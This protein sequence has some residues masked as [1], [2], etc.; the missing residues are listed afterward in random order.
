MTTAPNSAI[1]DP[2]TN[3]VLTVAPQS[4][5]DTTMS[6]A[7]N[8]I[9]ALY[10]RLSQEDARLG[11]S[12][13]I[14]NQKAI[15]LE[16]AKKNYFPNPVFF[17]DDG[18]SGTNYDRPGFQSML[19]EIE[20]GHIGIVITKDLSR[21]GRNSALTGLYTNFTFP[22]YGVRYIA[23]NDNYDTIDP[24]SVNNDFAG[25]KNWFN[26]FYARDTSRKIR[27]VQKAKGERGVPL[28]VNVPYGY[29]KD[30]EN[31][32]HWLVD[33]EAAAVVKHIFSMCME[34]RGP[35]QIAN[36]LWVDKVLT[37]TA[38][39]LSHGLSTNSPA[40][41]D[42]YRWDKRA[43]SLILERREYTGCTVNFKT[44]TNSIWDKKKHLNPVKNQA[45]FSDTHERIIDDDVFEKVQ[46][47][48]QQR[49]RMIRTGRSSIFSGL[50]YCADCG[51]KM[52]YGSSN[53]G[54]LDQDF[55][56]CS[57]HRKSKEKCNGHFIR[58]KVLDRL[59]L[60]HIQAVMGYILR[61]E[62]YF[63]TIMEEQLRVESYE[64]IRIRRK[65]LESNERRIAELKRL[66]IKIYEDNASG[67]LTDERYDMLSQTYEAE[68]KQLEAEAITLQ[69]EIEVQERQNEN[70]E[71]FIQKAHKY[72]GI[73]ELDG[74]ALRELVSA[75]Y[76]D[77]PDK[78]SGKRVQHIHIRYDGLGFIPLNELM[79]KET[80]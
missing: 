35:T 17:V 16:Y 54:D 26:E 80:A 73:E 12:L 8:K 78:S 22:Q 9:T 59:V 46:E 71:K 64:Q 62:D 34:G 42:P 5:E 61:H 29:V 40:P 74:Y 56:D 32:K 25:I 55:F 15:L 23:I 20:A 58:V 19:T 51:S 44:Y 77:A 63:R 30:P 49:H 3:P 66:F 33:P 7:T 69:Q 76:V 18:Y 70:I 37:P 79:K 67:R 4:K 24:N 1:L 53:N 68:Q 50:V 57:L 48:R 65:R 38:Y 72:V 36:Q 31:P 60:K 27:A 39:K 28:T 21:L 41:E 75:I 14:E 43:V 47:I 52:L 6:G 2:L 11:E 45:I 13:S 10:C